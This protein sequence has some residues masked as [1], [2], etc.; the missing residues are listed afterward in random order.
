MIIFNPQQE[1]FILRLPTEYGGEHNLQNE[2]KI[3]ETNV[4]FYDKITIRT[5][6]KNITIKYTFQKLPKKLDER[7]QMHVICNSCY[8]DFNGQ[9]GL[10]IPDMQNKK[11]HIIMTCTNNLFVS[12][13]GKVVNCSYTEYTSLLLKRLFI[14]SDNFIEYK[15]IILTYCSKNKP[16]LKPEEIIHFASNS[17]N[18]FLKFF[19]LI[20][21][22]IFLINYYDERL[23]H[24]QSIGGSGLYY[25]LD[26]IV[27]TNHVNKK[28]IFTY[29]NHEMYH[30]F[31]PSTKS[32]HET[33]F[34]E[35]FTEFFCRYCIMSSKDFTYEIN[36]KFLPQYYANPYKN[37]NDRIMTYNNFWK[38][39]LIQEL[40]YQKGFIYALYLLQTYKSKFINSYKNLCRKEYC[41]NLKTY[42]TNEMLKNIF[43]DDYFNDYIIRGKIIPIITEKTISINKPFFGFD[44]DTLFFDKTIKNIDKN[45]DAYQ[46]GVKNGKIDAYDLYFEKCYHITIIQNKKKIKFTTKSNETIYIPYLSS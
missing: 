26:F 31:N 7:T 34:N 1:T 8:C 2:I 6:K 10:I 5:N 17:W 18:K 30:H 41:K 3:L 23:S 37:M 36:N 39:R 35:G 32:G 42:Y 20:D 13:L 38:N 33:W 29:I 44:I 43:N 28:H 25:G 4:D 19:D 9:N 16:L 11:F 45:S 12:G 22:H 21:K 40:P 46:Q 27:Q 24:I 15:N 14:F